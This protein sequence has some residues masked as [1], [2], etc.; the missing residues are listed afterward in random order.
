MDINE[1]FA[2]AA[3]PE[4]DGHYFEAHITL[5]GEPNE[6]RSHVERIGWKFSAID[7]DPVLGPGLK[8]YATYFFNKRIGSAKAVDLLMESARIL[9]KRG[10]IVTRRKIELV[11]FDDRSSKTQC[12]GACPECVGE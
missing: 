6:V 1:L 2:S 5:R 4:I 9:E 12:I 7:G 3:T 10:C 11:L 8:C